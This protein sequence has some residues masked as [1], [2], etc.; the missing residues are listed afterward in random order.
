MNNIAVYI[1]VEQCHRTLMYIST[2][3]LQMNSSA[4]E[5]VEKGVVTV[6]TIHICYCVAITILLTSI[7]KYNLKPSFLIA[8]NYSY[9]RQNG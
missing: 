5:D 3:L 6:H 2:S 8:D 1:L 9:G 7:S 4:C